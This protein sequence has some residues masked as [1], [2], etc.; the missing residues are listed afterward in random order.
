MKPCAAGTHAPTP[1]TESC[2]HCEKG[3]YQD[4]EGKDDCKI[5]PRGN[6]CPSG[7]A[8]ELECLQGTWSGSLGLDD[9]SQCSAC[10]LGFYCPKGSVTPLPCPAGTVGQSPNLGSQLS[11][12][13]CAENTWSTPGSSSCNSCQRDHFL[14]PQEMSSA[15]IE[16]APCSQLG[17]H[18]TCLANVT[19]ET[20]DLDERWWR[21]GPRSKDLHK[22]AKNDVTGFTP[23]RGGKEAGVGG[24]G[25]CLE[26][27]VG[28]L[29]QL[30]TVETNWFNPQSSKCEE[31]PAAGDAIGQ[32]VGAVCGMLG[33]L[34]VLG[35]ALQYAS[36]RSAIAMML[37]KGLVLC[38]RRIHQLAT[39][40]SLVPKLKLVLAFY[41]S[42]A[43]LPTVYNVELPDLYYE[44]T[45]WMNIFDIDWS[46]FF[47]PGACLEGGYTS[48]L[49]LRSVGPL[50]LIVVVFLFS[51]AVNIGQ[52]LIETE[53]VGRSF[54]QLGAK[55]KMWTRALVKS[56]PSVLFLSFCLCAPTASAIFKTWDCV[57]YVEDSLAPTGNPDQV[58][59]AGARFLRSDLRTTCNA[60]D[61]SE[62]TRPTEY[63]EIESIAWVF[64]IIYSIVFPCIFMG[65]LL[66]SRK[67]LRQR[68]STQLVRATAFS[69]PSPSPR[70]N[71][72]PNPN[73]N[74]GPNPNPKPE[75]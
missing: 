74:P 65:V 19:L 44:W 58:T 75:P 73:P 25:Y 69:S 45:G 38:V 22:C 24:S 17:G 14:L 54:S 39:A 67:T 11:C 3:K 9:H 53:S 70:P 64:A 63:A 46:N 7:A 52:A 42:A 5:C 43:V 10:P 23:C 62:I 28:P 16:C 1:E 29:C 68:R 31:C 35:L 12:T 27:H 51:F 56:L 47:I 32:L 20:I 66:P 26:G 2:T 30:C 59:S 48:R 57:E 21:L 34:M 4:E 15:S 60:F 37:R 40:V 55:G 41:Q 8:R 50:V 36:R 49:L 72:N 61:G 71:P 13:P 18:A 6:V 33:L